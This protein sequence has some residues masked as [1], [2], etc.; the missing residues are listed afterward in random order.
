MIGHDK[1][2]ETDHMEGILSVTIIKNRIIATGSIDTSIKLWELN[3]F[4]AI[5]TLLGHSKGVR[6]LV[7]I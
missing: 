1:I 3:E 6:A 5:A 4:D 2:I 7:Y